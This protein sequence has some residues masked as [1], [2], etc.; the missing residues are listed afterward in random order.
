MTEHD[1][2]CWPEYYEPLERGD[3]TL[4][5]RLNDRNYRVGDVLHQREWEPLEHRYTGRSSRYLVTHII[6]GGEWLVPGYVA[7]SIRRLP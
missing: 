2:K 6:R 4:E 1:V 3:K 5:L 7:M